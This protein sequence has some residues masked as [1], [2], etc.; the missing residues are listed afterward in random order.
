[1]N[2]DNDRMPSKTAAK[3]GVVKNQQTAATIPNVDKTFSALIMIDP[4][5]TLGARIYI[6]YG[7]FVNYC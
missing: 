6:D 7:D 3:S 5:L 4:H 2:I 1:M